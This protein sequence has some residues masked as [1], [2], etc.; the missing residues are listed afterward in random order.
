[1]IYESWGQRYCDVPF[2]SV[3]LLGLVKS[4]SE[5]K[6][7]WQTRHASFAALFCH[8][9]CQYLK[10]LSW[11]QG[12]ITPCGSQWQEGDSSTFASSSEE[13]VDDCLFKQTSKVNCGHEWLI[14][15]SRASAGITVVVILCKYVQIDPWVWARGFRA[16]SPCL[17]TAQ[18]WTA[19]VYWRGP[20]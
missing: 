15:G 20:A 7:W 3:N 18:W 10:H 1:M 6:F 13:N 12:I 9:W 4:H 16:V 17:F 5:G 11:Q 2:Y 14:L 8:I 19:K